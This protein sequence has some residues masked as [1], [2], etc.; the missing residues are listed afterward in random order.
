MKVLI[1]D[2]DAQIREFLRRYLETSGW[3]VAE[4]GNGDEAIAEF[5]SEPPNVVVLDQ[6]MPG[7]TGIEVATK[8][9]AEGFSGH[10]VLF[11]AYLNPELRARAE[12]LDLL[13]IS[14]VDTRVI[15]RYLETLASQID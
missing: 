13:P 4:A 11:S 6:M 3:D 2:D 1:V 10:M 9:R 15:F 12:Q 5:A 14:K 7:M 8:I